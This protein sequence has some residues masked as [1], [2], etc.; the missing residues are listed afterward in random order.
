MEKCWSMCHNSF[1]QLP[2]I[3]P[4]IVISI[5]SHRGFTG[6]MLDKCGGNY[7]LESSRV[8]LKPILDNLDLIIWCITP[9]LLEYMKYMNGWKGLKS[10]IVFRQTNKSSQ[11]QMNTSYS[12]MKTPTACTVPCLWWSMASCP[13]PHLNPTISL[14]QM[15]PCQASN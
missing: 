7:L 12:I 10:N 3:C 9:S 14:K 2:D 8:F 6:L 11:F 4:Q 13:A 5:T 15:K 1:P